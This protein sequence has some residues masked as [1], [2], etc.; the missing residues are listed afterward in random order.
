MEKE[1][2]RIYVLSK[3]EPARAVLKMGLPLIAGMFIMV[4]YNLVDTYFIGLTR[5]DYQLAAVNL[6]YPVMMVAIAV[7][8]IV[9]SGASS[10]CRMSFQGMGKAQYAFI[11]TFIRQLILYVPLLLLLN[12]AFGFG[13]MIWAQTVTEVIMMIV[14]VILLT[15]VINKEKSELQEV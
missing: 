10:M 13:G 11:I 8:N 3:E 1:D 6:A 2:K 4:M 12:R 7:S 9:S 5:D 15:R 14:S